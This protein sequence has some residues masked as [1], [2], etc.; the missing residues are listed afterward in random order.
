MHYLKEMASGVVIINV[1]K[2]SV[3]ITVGGLASLPEIFQHLS[4]P[5]ANVG[6]IF[7]NRR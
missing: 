1:W 3:E 6:M 7:Q 5:V 2:S 4:V